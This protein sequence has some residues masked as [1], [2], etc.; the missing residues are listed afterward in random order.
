MRMQFFSAVI[1][2]MLYS[3]ASHAD[4]FLYFNS[5]QGD[6][7]GQGIEQTWTTEDGVFT[8]VGDIS[9]NVITVEFTGNSR[10]SLDFAAPRGETLRPGPYEDATRYPF[11]SPTLPG[12]SISG[13]GRGCNTL[14]GRFHVIEISYSTEGEIN[15]FAVDFEQHCEGGE[16]ALFGSLRYNATVG[17]PLKVDVKA[18]GQ[19]TPVIVKL[20]DAVEIS[21]TTDAGD[22]EGVLAEYWLGKSGTYGSQ[23]FN[24]RRWVYRFFQPKRWL[25]QPVTTD[26]YIFN[27][28]PKVPGVYMFRIFFHH[29]RLGSP[30]FKYLG[31]Q[32]DKIPRDR[33]AG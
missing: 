23:W 5:E 30:V 6:S 11:Q 24:G 33:C 28:I 19:D 31:R 12:L 4:T 26:E 20:D 9:S 29:F 10:W 8:P 16:P 14:T 7:I 32:F 27:W 13:D 15:R 1:G 2:V 21:V 25:R 17:F 22:D 18:N 3:A